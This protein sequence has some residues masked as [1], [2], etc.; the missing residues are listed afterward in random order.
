VQPAIKE[1]D[2]LWFRMAEDPTLYVYCL[3]MQGRVGPPS[4]WQPLLVPQVPVN[5]LPLI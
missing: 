3:R 1:D 2:D 5:P 4:N